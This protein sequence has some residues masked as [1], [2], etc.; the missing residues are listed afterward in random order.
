MAMDGTRTSDL[1]IR[2]VGKIGDLMS[3]IG[4]AVKRFWFDNCTQS[5]ASLTYT[6][7]LALVPLMT[8][9]VAILS[10]FPAFEAVRESAQSLIFNNL[11][12]Q[13]G[14]VVLEN[15]ESFASRAGQLTAVGVIAL[16][17]TAVLL[18]AS[19]EGA[20][21]AI[22]RVRESRPLLVRLLSFW[23]IL[24]ITPMLFAASL[25][26]TTRLVENPEFQQ[27]VPIWDGFVGW[28]PLLFQFIGFAVLYRIIPNRLVRTIDAVIGAA[29]AAVLFELSKTGFALYL[30]EFPS[31]QTIYGALATV[32]IFLVWLY[33]AWSIVLFG[34]VITASLPEWRSGKL[35]GASADTMMP[36]Q[37]LAVSVAI[38]RELSAAARLGVGIR[39]N[40]LVH[41]VPISGAMM[42]DALDAL[43]RARFVERTSSDA[44]LLSRDLASVSLYDMAKAMGMGLRGSMIKLPP[45]LQKPFLRH[46]TETLAHAD[47]VQQEILGRPITELIDDPQAELPIEPPIRLDDRRR[48]RDGEPGGTEDRGP[49]GGSAG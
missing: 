21:N 37:R 17:V 43:R 39:I 24:T 44:W 47:R 22:W 12:P 42:E 1:L 6:S 31:Y 3:F 30:T 35:F 45:A 36:G 32:P 8:I 11:V 9:T 7:L 34:A 48:E 18:L 5:A 46:T 26:L 19:I 13:V 29:V 25:S 4:Y 16:V 40:T 14:E 38:L 27:V 28:L 15:I 49:A 2:G 10:A 20:F 33:L 23:A 41:R